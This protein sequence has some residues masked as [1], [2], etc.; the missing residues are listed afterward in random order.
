MDFNQEKPI[1][2]LG[3]IPMPLYM[4]DSYPNLSGI[5]QPFRNRNALRDFEY[6]QRTYSEQIKEYQKKISEVLDRMDYEGSM[7]YDEY[8]DIYSMRDLADT[9]V[10][11]LKRQQA[12]LLNGQRLSDPR[13]NEVRNMESDDDGSKENGIKENVTNFTELIQVLVCDEVFKRRRR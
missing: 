2:N 7:I 5:I 6:L 10:N 11:I 1:P 4:P 12:D 9:V 3:R 13:E 8:P